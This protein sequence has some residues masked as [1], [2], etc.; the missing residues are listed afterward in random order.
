MWM[1]MLMF[2][3]P[4]QNEWMEKK[5][6]R[7]HDCSQCAHLFIVSSLKI[8]FQGWGGRAV[9]DESRSEDVKRDYLQL[10][11]HVL[12]AVQQLV[13]WRE[14]GGQRDISDDAIQT[15]HV[16][17]QQAWAFI[18]TSWEN[19]T[20]TRSDQLSLGVWW[21]QVG[22]FFNSVLVASGKHACR[23]MK[24]KRKEL[25]LRNHTAG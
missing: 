1:V 2:L 19:R 8:V 13:R 7:M 5:E 22:Y 11:R 18:I 21:W 14:G 16:S 25:P 4:I 12:E 6:K 24:H 23:S 20:R 17:D 15:I 3:R 10:L 9:T